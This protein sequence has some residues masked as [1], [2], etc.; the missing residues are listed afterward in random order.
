MGKRKHLHLLDWYILIPFILLSLLGI[1]MVYSSST[2]IAIHSGTTALDFLIKQSIYF[3]VGLMLMY[4]FYRL[5]L[6]KLRDPVFIKAMFWGITAL[7]VFVL[8]FSGRVNGAK[9]WINLGFINLQPE[10]FLKIVIILYFADYI[11]AQKTYLYEDY[12][13]VMK[14]AWGKM[15]ILVLLVLLQPDTGGTAIDLFI[16]L[17]MSMSTGIKKHRPSNLMF[18]LFLSYFVMVFMLS[19]M[20]LH[21]SIWTQHYQLQRL[22]AFVNPFQNVRTSGRQLVNSYYAVSNGGLFGV[23]LGNSVQ[24]MGYL[25]EAN[26]DFILSIIAEELGTFTV[27]IILFLLLVIILKAIRLGKKATN[28]YD[29]LLCYG[30]SAYFFIETLINVGAV[31]GVLPISGVTLPLISY[32]GSSMLALC[33]CIGILLNVSKREK[34]YYSEN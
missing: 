25:P 31:I 15:I 10:E 5:N 34:R 20:N 32:G 9:G 12:F 2:Y 33:I 23:G 6:S 1:V 16:I 29:T 17:V 14:P 26:T 7:L 19:H 4:F 27:L 28:L 11:D 24:K 3:V 30:I 13:S 21:G 22:V 18:L 8:I